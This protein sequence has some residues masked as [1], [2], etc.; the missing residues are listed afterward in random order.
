MG[1]S[2]KTDCMTFRTLTEGELLLLNS[3]VWLA[4]TLFC[5]TGKHARE[6][7]SEGVGE[8]RR[9]KKERREDTLA[10]IH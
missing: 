1:S 9:K 4:F 8:A 7:G 2:Q 3:F 5:R 6:G 10:L